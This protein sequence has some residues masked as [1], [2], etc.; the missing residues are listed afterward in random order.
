MNDMCMTNG[1]A[2]PVRGPGAALTGVLA[3]GAGLSVAAI[4]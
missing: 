2:T 3:A 4:Y 1:H